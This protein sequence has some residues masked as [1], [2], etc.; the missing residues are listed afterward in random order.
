MK[1]SSDRPVWM[2]KECIP[3]KR[4]EGIMS[5]GIVVCKAGVL[6]LVDATIP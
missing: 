4:F 2:L 3:K 6:S 5:E 1:L